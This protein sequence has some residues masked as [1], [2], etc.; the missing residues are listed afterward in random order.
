MATLSPKE[1]SAINRR[2]RIAWF[3]SL[4]PTNVAGVY[5]SDDHRTVLHA[6]CTP[7]HIRQSKTALAFHGPNVGFS[8]IV[9]VQADGWKWD[10]H[11][12][13]PC[14]ACGEAA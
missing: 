1:Y 6:R 11:Y 13:R 10:R 14:D 8:P 12:G 9:T 7:L 3:G 4:A 5:Y 2:E